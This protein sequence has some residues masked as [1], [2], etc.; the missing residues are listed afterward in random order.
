MNLGISTQVSNW[1]RI[2][3]Q[4]IIVAAGIAL[5]VSALATGVVLR[6][7]TPSGGPKATSPASIS[8][9]APLPQTYIYLVGSQ[10]QAAELTAGFA[11]AAVETGADALRQAIV[12]DSPEAEASL[13]TMIGELSQAGTAG[14]VNIVDVRPGAPSA[15]VFSSRSDVLVDSAY[16][17]QE[18][19]HPAFAF[20]APAASNVLVDSAYQFQEEVYPNFAPATEVFVDSY[21]QFQEATY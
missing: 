12:I 20:E 1:K 9:Q 10:E 16:Q 6:D 7:T 18:Q 2:K 8:R 14:S 13:Q 17:V 21:Y 4:H 19:S 15:D 5:A 3:N 11:N